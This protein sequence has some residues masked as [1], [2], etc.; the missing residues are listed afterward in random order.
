MNAPYNLSLI[1]FRLPIFL[2]HNFCH[3][4]S[5]LLLVFSW[6]FSFTE[7]ASNFVPT[8]RCIPSSAAPLSLLHF[9]LPSSPLRFAHSLPSPLPSLVDSFSPC[10]SSI[11]CFCATPMQEEFAPDLAGIDPTAAQSFP[12]GAAPLLFSRKK[13][14]RIK[15][16]P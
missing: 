11:F 8:N 4:A 5:F 7:P 15:E 6:V 3:R 1:S 13:S 16:C 10:T 14:S 2:N 9:P 12:R